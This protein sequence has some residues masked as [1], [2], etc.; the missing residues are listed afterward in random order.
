MAAVLLTANSLFVSHPTPAVAQP[1]T[2]LVT[3]TFTGATVD[4]RFAG[5]GSACLT[6]AAP[7]ATPG[8]VKP[9]PA[10]RVGPVPPGNGAP[11]GYLQLTDSS[12]NQAGAV[13]F[14]QP[15]PANQGLEVSFEQWQYGNNPANPPADG[16]SFF[17]VDGAG[18]LTA[19]GAFGGS[20][21]YAQKL[22]DGNPA[23][24]FL[25]GVNN[26]YLGIGLDVLGN[27]FGDWE[28]RGHGCEQRSPAGTAFRVPAPGPNMVTV[29]GPGDGI[30]GYCF[31]T[32]TTSNFTTNEPWPSTL[33]GQLQGT[34]TSIP[35]GTTP[36]QAQAL[37]DPSK[38]TV[39]VRITPAPN[40]QVTVDV[41]FNDTT[42]THRVLD[43]AAPQAVPPSYKL[44]F[45]AS[46]GAFTDV[47][48]I[49]NVQIRSAE[50]LPRLNLIKQVVIDP[51]L[52][53][54][55]GLGTS[56][57]YQLVVTNTGA[58]PITQLVVNDP[59]FAAV[60]CPTTTLA[61]GATVVCTANYVV[62]QADVDRGT[63]V[64]TATA[65]GAGG[66]AMVTSP[67]A[68][69]SL[70]LGA[71]T[72]G[73]SLT[74]FAEPTTV[75]AAGQQ[76]KY[77]YVV[78]NSGTV[79]VSGLDF[80]E[81][82]SGTGTAPDIVCPA[83]AVAPGDHVTCTGSYTVTQADL[84]AGID[85]SNTARATGA[86]P[87]R[88]PVMS[89][90]ATATVDVVQ[91]PSL[92]LVKSV[93][94]STVTGAGQTVTY[95]FLVTNNGHVTVNGLT[96][97]EIAGPALE[98]SCPNTTLAPGASTTCTATYT[99]TDADFTGGGITNTATAS[100]T[101]LGGVPVT[102][103]NSTARFD[104]VTGT[105]SLSLT[106]IANPDSVTR[107]GQ[108]VVYNYVI[109]NTGDVSITS[110]SVGESAFIGIS[111]P[112]TTLAAGEQTVCT[113][114]YIVTQA[115]VNAGSI[116]NTATA[117]GTAN[118]STVTSPQSSATVDIPAAPS[119]T[120]VKSADPTAVTAAGQQITYTFQVINNG[121]VTLN[122]VGVSETTFSG[123][124]QPVPTISC[125]TTTLAPNQEMTCT[126]RY[127]V[128]VEDMSADD[129]HDT[130]V[131]TATTPQVSS[132]PSSASVD[133]NGNSGLKA[134]KKAE[135]ST[136]KE[137][138]Q[139]VTYSVIVTN[140]GTTTLTNVTVADV[141]FTGAGT[142]PQFTCPPTAAS[143]APGQSVTCIGT[144]VVTE[145]DL[146]RGSISNT[147]IAT[148]QTPDGTTISSAPA[149]AGVKVEKGKGH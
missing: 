84:D 3:E 28:Q 63:I 47:H 114:T 82:L 66:G 135:P 36:A 54:V 129:I 32:A 65:S 37:L 57:P 29:R 111:C 100:G 61:P 4:P 101:T 70:P 94:P 48:L 121:S 104:T 46:T 88:D 19:P 144:Y 110:L 95:S 106:K 1:G 97:N 24:P 52:P 131:A 58:T 143:L 45:A 77:E 75:S 21:G 5:F 139:Q 51:P 10:A 128:T 80:V 30:N 39:T 107:A 119:L 124:G 98:P 102:S 41:D 96:I 83:T 43:F 79:T 86:A 64:N 149:D 71:G 49:R 26:G 125:P 9:C 8:S 130:A 7:D 140:T 85:L 25:P 108:Q 40:P 89:P 120:L 81:S 134:V 38:R 42:G 33:P 15:I 17:L 44:G 53:P 145:A 56:V 109:T 142:P 118:G 132:P 136:I 141:R 16:I 90:P 122:G 50:P 126:S 92:A 123:T 78:S 105:T 87:N 137:A 62:T 115:D 116:T 2:T 18:T 22:P 148:A 55:I 68:E 138:G 99:V 113:R 103:P 14:N 59:N 91:A 23:N 60:N 35:P 13:L 117:T 73:L 11:F 69:A 146:D 12:T 147:A 67:Q 76:V 6:G 93:N 133:V 112:T 34:L 72:P 127:T 74:K 20:L 31:L 27:Y